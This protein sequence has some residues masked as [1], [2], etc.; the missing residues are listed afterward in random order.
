MNTRCKPGD[1]AIIVIDV[2]GC[3][4]N[5]GRI[6][7]VR[8][9]LRYSYQY[10]QECWRIKPLHGDPMFVLEADGSFTLERIYWKSA[11]QHPDLWM[12]PIRP[13]RLSDE[14]FDQLKLLDKLAA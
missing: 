2:P 4:A 10:Q 3:D 12:L 13:E 5:L 6:V 14:V 11:I 9:P 1:L 8:N 7:Q